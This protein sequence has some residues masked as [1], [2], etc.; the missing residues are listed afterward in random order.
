MAAELVAHGTNKMTLSDPFLNLFVKI[1]FSTK[2]K[3][4]AGSL[5]SIQ[6]TGEK[7]FPVQFF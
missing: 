4:S 2:V 5:I 6:T 1:L 7:I 3:I